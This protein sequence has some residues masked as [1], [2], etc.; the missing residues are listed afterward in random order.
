MSDNRASSDPS[1]DPA[2]GV[3]DTPVSEA[4]DAA[5]DM[6]MSAP[7]GEHSGELPGEDDG[8]APH[9]ATQDDNAEASEAGQPSQ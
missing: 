2:D 5:P 6:D 8:G 7:P 4:D 1:T 9:A 3:K